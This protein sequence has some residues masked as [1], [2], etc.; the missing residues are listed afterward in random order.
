MSK[1]IFILCLIT[2]KFILLNDNLKGIKLII[3]KK[4]LNKKKEIK[5]CLCAVAK[6]ENNYIREFVNYYKK[7][8]VDK[9][10]I[11]DNNNLNG[12]K[13]DNILSDYIN[14]RYVEIINKRGKFYSQFLIYQNCYQR[15]YKKYNWLIFYDIDEF[16]FLKNYENIKDFLTE[17]KF[18]KCKSI[19][20][21]WK[22][23][24]DNDF[25]YYENKSL[26]ER[27]PKIYINNNY[28]VGK[29]IIR[30]NLK[31]IKIRSTHLLDKRLQRCNG[32]GKIFK[33]LGYN[34]KI[35]DYF[36]YYIDHY[37][38]K[39]TEEFINKISKG[40]CVHGYNIRYKIKK[41]QNYFIV[42]KITKKKYKYFESKTGLNI[43]KLINVNLKLLI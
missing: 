19:Y 40:D 13:F 28:C 29:T 34:C 9:I 23:H 15:N 35:P 38:Y 7:F 41:I 32:F 10:F 22:I 11:Y 31:K 24:T 4:L 37:Y 20:L 43:S 26:H 42:N 2:F 36:F 16:I 18:E 25:L 30:G 8:G 17:K 1:M 33:A 3:K 14:S 12:E 27:F 6:Q 5:I 39:S 21:N